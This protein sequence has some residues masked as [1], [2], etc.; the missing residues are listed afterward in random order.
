P[1]A[2]KSQIGG[3]LNAFEDYLERILNLAEAKVSE[4]RQQASSARS[5]E[6]NSL[7]V[8]VETLEK[9]V[10]EMQ[11]TND[12][13]FTRFAGQLDAVRG[14]FGDGNP[15]T[16]QLAALAKPEPM[17]SPRNPFRG[18]WRRPSRYPRLWL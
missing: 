16:L 3:Y 8:E 13:Y 18:L 2:S 12:W 14:H 4:L 11:Q 9:S 1:E 7:R 6:G 10:Y 5:S 17:L 15:A